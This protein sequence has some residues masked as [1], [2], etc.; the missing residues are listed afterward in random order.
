MSSTGDERSGI[1]F[2][3]SLLAGLLITIGGAFTLTM[4]LTTP[5]PAWG[6]GMMGMMGGAFMGMFWG[7]GIISSIALILGILIIVGAYMIKT[8]PE[9]TSTWGTLILVSSVIA[10]LGG[11]GFI[12]GS[13]LGII[14]GILALV[15]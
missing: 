7:M 15:K 11:G 4:F 8:K 12:I 13:I 10:L 14:A 5:F 9:Q 3:L 6:G 1:V 2:A